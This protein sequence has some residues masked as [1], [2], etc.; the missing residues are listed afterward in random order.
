MAAKLSAN[1]QRQ[2]ATLNLKI[3]I[4]WETKP[5]TPLKILLDCKW[6]REK[7]RGLKPC[8]LY[9]DDDD[10]NVNNNNNSNNNN[11]NNNI[12]AHRR[13]TIM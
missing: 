10:D 5:R 6:Y 9:D 1:E 13:S 3:S 11:S 2:T 12:V 8:K 7:L 4:M